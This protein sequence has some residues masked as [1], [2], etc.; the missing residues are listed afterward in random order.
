MT[1]P[2]D[3]RGYGRRP[4]HPRWPEGARIALSF[5][6]NHEEGAENYHRR[7]RIFDAPHEH[8]IVV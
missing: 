7:V 6:L 8:G 1:Y 4:P 3:L 2:R 5:V